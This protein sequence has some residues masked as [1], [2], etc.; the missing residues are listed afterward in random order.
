MEDSFYL[1]VVGPHLS[2]S[3]LCR[4]GHR[5]IL[6]DDTVIIAGRMKARVMIATGCLILGVVEAA[7]AVGLSAV[8]SFAATS[9]S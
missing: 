9:S 3:D 4:S 5:F 7:F 6:R 2:M 1:H 8:V